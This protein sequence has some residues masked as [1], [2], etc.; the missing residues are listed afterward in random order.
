MNNLEEENFLEKRQTH[1][2]CDEEYE[3]LMK[4]WNKQTNERRNRFYWENY[5]SGRSI[6]WK[7]AKSKK[8]RFLPPEIVR[9]S[10][11]HSENFREWR[12]LNSWLWERME[13]PWIRVDDIATRRW[14]TKCRII[15]L[16]KERKL[17]PTRE[18]HM[19]PMKW[20]NIY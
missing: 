14:K 10:E 8:K 2:A 19:R 18:G 6:N 4:H 20:R 17:N 15:E 1:C 16:E 13:F 3:H 12:L 9:D 7:W 5:N 11:K